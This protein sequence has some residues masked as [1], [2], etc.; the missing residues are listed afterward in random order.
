VM[1]HAGMCIIAAHQAGTDADAPATAK[2]TFP[3]TRTTQHITFSKPKAM[4]PGQS[5]QLRASSSAG[6]KV[7]LVSVTEHLCTVT[8]NTVTTKQRPGTCTVVA[9]A[10]GTN[11]YQPAKPVRRDITMK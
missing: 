7:T 5:Q 1:A 10:A 9:H 3:V 6:L 4:R 11:K 2:Q 8:G